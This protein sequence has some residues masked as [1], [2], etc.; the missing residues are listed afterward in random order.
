MYE[1]DFSH[2][3]GDFDHF[4]SFLIVLDRFRPVLDRLV[5]FMQ[6]NV[7]LD[8]KRSKCKILRTFG[9]INL[10]SENPYL[11]YIIT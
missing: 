9:E 6:C 7:K 4:W 8:K 2:N 10:M 3:F 11:D 5:S 1:V